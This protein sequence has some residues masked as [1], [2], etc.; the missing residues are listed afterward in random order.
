M[1]QIEIGT[2]LEA[3][4]M[5]KTERNMAMAIQMGR[6][7]RERRVDSI[8]KYWSLLALHKLH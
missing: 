7:S 8:Y 5:M 2:V 6:V 4:V 1:T 3:R